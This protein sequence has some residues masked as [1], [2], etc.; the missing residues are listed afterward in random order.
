MNIHA[1]VVVLED[2][3]RFPLVI[4]IISSIVVGNRFASVSG[5][6]IYVFIVLHFYFKWISIVSEI[7]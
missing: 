3:D 7:S 4:E 2:V 1:C 6:Y 5:I